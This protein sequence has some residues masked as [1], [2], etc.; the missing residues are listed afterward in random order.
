MRTNIRADLTADVKRCA[1]DAY[2]SFSTD[3]GPLFI[4]NPNDTAQ[5]PALILDKVV[6]NY[7]VENKL[8]CTIGNEP[9]G[10]D[11]VVQVLKATAQTFAPL[12]ARATA[13]APGLAVNYMPATH[14]AFVLLKVRTEPPPASLSSRPPS[15]APR[16]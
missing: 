11:A 16:S 6:G 1:A 5:P 7:A 12:S 3:K 2:R 15:A 14:V 9:F 13:N 4:P 10:N 8:Y